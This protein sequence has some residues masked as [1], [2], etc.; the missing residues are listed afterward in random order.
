MDIEQKSRW[1]IYYYCVVVLVRRRFAVN[2]IASAPGLFA[3][4]V[5]TIEEFYTISSRH[6]ETKWKMMCF[7][8]VYC[9]IF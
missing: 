5:Y 4:P 3:G 2:C 6:D 8:I 1:A 9:C 7:N